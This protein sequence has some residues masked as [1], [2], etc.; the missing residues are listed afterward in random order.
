MTELFCVPD[1]RFPEITVIVLKTLYYFYSIDTECLS[2]IRYYMRPT[3]GIQ[4]G[5]YFSSTPRTVTTDITY[6][7]STGTITLRKEVRQ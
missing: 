2:M 3:T 4:L 1:S 5:N 7:Y 6:D